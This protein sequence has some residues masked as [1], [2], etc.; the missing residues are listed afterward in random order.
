MPRPMPRRRNRSPGS[1]P[2]TP[3]ILPPSPE[4]PTW[5]LP[6]T[7]DAAP[8]TPPLRWDGYNDVPPPTFSAFV[9]PYELRL[10]HWPPHPEC[11]PPPP[12]PPNFEWM[13]EW[14][15]NRWT[16]PNESW[17]SASSRPDWN[18]SLRQNSCQVGF[19]IDENTTSTSIRA[20]DKLARVQSVL[21]VFPSKT[22]A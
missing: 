11:P 7:P 8:S 2:R 9:D 17:R 12:G 22:S 10:D 18:E 20:K 1:P 4:T 13:Q 16:P 15:W 21:A 3:P 19:T 5:G 14:K 6:R